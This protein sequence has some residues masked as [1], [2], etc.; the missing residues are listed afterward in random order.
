MTPGPLRCLV[1]SGF[2]CQPLS[3]QGD[4][5]GQADSRSRPLHAVLKIAWEQQCSA[6]LLENVKGALDAS[7]IQ[8]GLQKLAWSLNMDSMQTVVWIAHGLVVEPDGGLL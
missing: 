6:L 2:P 8:E 1:A 5:K 7:Y 4:M 3:S